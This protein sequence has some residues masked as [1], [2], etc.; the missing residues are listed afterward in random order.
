M[1][2]EEK[3][4]LVQALVAATS[5]DLQKIRN[6]KGELEKELA[7][8]SVVEKALVVLLG[9]EPPKK[10]RM[11]NARAAKE[12]NKQQPAPNVVEPGPTSFEENEKLRQR[13]MTV[14]KY[15]QSNRPCTKDKLSEVTGYA[16]TARLNLGQV[17]DCD[18]FHVN[19]DGVVSL[20]E[21]GSRIN[22]IGAGMGKTA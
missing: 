21:K 16:Q 6:R 19:P 5:D 1:A 15:L 2:K 17:L 13:R 14:V 22:L 11:A 10:D 7:S 3:V 9:L 18:W 12:A 8:L 4:D 20:T